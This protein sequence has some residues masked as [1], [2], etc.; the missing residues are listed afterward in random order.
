MIGGDATGTFYASRLLSKEPM[1]ETP[2]L[3]VKAISYNKTV[4][5]DAVVKSRWD[6]EN[7]RNHPRCRHQPGRGGAVRLSTGRF[8][9]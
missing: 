2:G 8:I 4:I 5:G 6:T 1:I 3:S 9:L 7:T